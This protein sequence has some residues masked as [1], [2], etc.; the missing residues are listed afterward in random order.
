MKLWLK[1]LL[2]PEFPF[3]SPAKLMIAVKDCWLLLWTELYPR[4]P[5]TSSYAEA[6]TQYLRMWLYLETELLKRRPSSNEAIQMGP[7]L[8]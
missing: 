5:N 6:L 4:D 7:N 8:I 2:R 1:K 3:L